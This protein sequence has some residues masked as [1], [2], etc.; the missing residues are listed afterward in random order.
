MRSVIWW[1]FQP[2]VTHR[3]VLP[4]YVY[5]L[6]GIFRPGMSSAAMSHTTDTSE[7]F[8]TSEVFCTS[9]ASY[10]SGLI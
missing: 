4:R 3:S 7:V 6:C 8:R 9:E 1:T 2:A 5:S 10:N